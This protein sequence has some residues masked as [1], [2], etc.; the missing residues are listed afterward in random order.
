MAPPP[1]VRLREKDPLQ[2]QVFNAQVNNFAQNAF[3]TGV[4][5]LGMSLDNNDSSDGESSSESVRGLS[6]HSKKQAKAK[7]KYQQANGLA[8]E[9]ARKRLPDAAEAN[10]IYVKDPN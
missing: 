2:Q 4:N 8:A 5:Q 9:G 6:P 7:K 10:N 3:I 1:K